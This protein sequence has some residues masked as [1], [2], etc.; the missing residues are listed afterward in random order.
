VAQQ[1]TTLVHISSDHFFELHL[2]A[3]DDFGLLM[4][5]LSREMARTVI[6]L[7]E[8]IVDQSALIEK[9]RQGR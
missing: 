9:G 2:Q 4:I 1:A 3:P 8:V 7:A 6:T 5:N